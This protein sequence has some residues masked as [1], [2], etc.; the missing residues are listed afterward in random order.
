MSISMRVME[1]PSQ[2]SVF[3]EDGLFDHES[4][5]GV[6][7]DHVRGAVEPVAAVGLGDRQRTEREITRSDAI[8]DRLPAC[9][10][11]SVI[12]APLTS[13]NHIDPISVHCHEEDR[14]GDAT[15]DYVADVAH[16]AERAAA[17][18][19]A[20]TSVCRGKKYQRKP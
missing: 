4:G 1:F 20:L 10:R 16:P 5:R 19:A 13:M 7:F 11:R 12:T 6:D 15:L 8:T 2:R 14:H 18:L 17:R 3:F 9:E